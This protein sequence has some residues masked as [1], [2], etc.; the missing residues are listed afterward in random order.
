MAGVAG[1][2]RRVETATRLPTGLPLSDGANPMSDEKTLAR[3]IEK[4]RERLD[5]LVKDDLGSEMGGVLRDIDQTLGLIERSI[6]DFK[7]MLEALVE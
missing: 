3:L 6:A 1:R 2:G 7:T 4:F 5:D